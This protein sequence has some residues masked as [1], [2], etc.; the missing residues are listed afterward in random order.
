VKINSKIPII[1]LILVLF[2]TIIYFPKT[3]Q[4]D[5]LVNNKKAGLSGEIEIGVIS[6]T[7][8]NF[9]KYVYF[10]GLAEE[11]LNKKC[12]E[13]GFNASFKFSVYRCNGSAAMALETTQYLHESGVYLIVG[14]GWS[15]QLW[16]MRTYVYTRG[17]LVISPSSTNPQGH[18]VQDDT[19]YR[20]TP[21]DYVIG[22][23][24]A[25]V[26]Y[27]Y[28]VEKMIVLERDDAWAVGIGDWFAEEYEIT[29]GDVI[30]RVKYPSATSSDFS[31]Y[32]NMIESLISE[33]G[34]D[35]ETGM[36]LLG[37]SETSAILNEL[38]NYPS[39]VNVTWFSTDAVANSLEIDT[40]SE[41]ILSSV[42]LV[43]P[44]HIPVWC[45]YSSTVARDYHD[46]FGEVFGF[47]EANIYDSCMVL[48]LS[49]LEAGST[50]TSYVKEVL[51][52]V[53]GDFVGLTGPCGLDEYGDRLDFKTGLYAVGYDPSLRW[54]V[55]G[56]YHSPTDEI[57]WENN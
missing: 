12:N 34:V 51:S 9:E 31:N 15:S 43:S 46:R 53:A 30:G 21:H 48:G 33:T 6:S 56:Y 27:D 49:V 55:I 26:A 8:E 13:S 29:G 45:N 1:F 38:V 19:I 54:M 3:Q 39:L 5:T 28:G 32:L 10:A 11:V 42:K 2:V 24:M 50:N 40:V 23:I 17:M 16:V 25:H 35:G 4:T 44:Q 37:F 36:F 57:I 20:L 47:F 41:E 18:M 7:S 22:K 52:L 14:G